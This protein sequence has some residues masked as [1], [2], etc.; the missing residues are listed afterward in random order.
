MLG[1]CF[2]EVF[3]FNHLISPKLQ[4][5]TDFQKLNSWESKGPDPPN[6]TL[7]PQEIPP[8]LL[9]GTINHLLVP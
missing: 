1:K 4:E 8:A 3:F 5:K 2:F 6:A 7:S 9:P